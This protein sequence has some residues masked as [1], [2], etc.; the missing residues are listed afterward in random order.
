MTNARPLSVN[1]PSI[2]GKV[3]RDSTGNITYAQAIGFTVYI[4]YPDTDN[5]YK[6]ILSWEG[7]FIKYMDTIKKE[8]NKNGL[9]VFYFTYKS[10]DDSI[11][12]STSGDIVFIT[13][14][15]TIMCTFTC[16]ALSRFRNRVTGHGLAGMVGLLAVAMG[17]ASAFGIVIICK[18]KFVS[19]VGVLPFLV[20]GV[21]I[22]DMFIIL[23]ELDRTN[24][25]LET[26]ELLATVLSN[27]GG[28]VTMTTLTDLV[29]FAVSTMSAFPAIQIFCTYAA[30]ALTFS[31]LMIMTFFVAFLVYEVN[32]IK[33]KRFDT[34]P[35][36]KSTTF[37]IEKEYGLI[38]DAKK[39]ISNVVMTR[40]GQFLMMRYVRVTVMILSAGLLAAGVVGA[41]GIT[42][43]FT[44]Q[45]LGKDGSEYIKFLD[46]DAAY[47]PRP[48]LVNIVVPGTYQL[49]SSQNQDEY[50]KLS[51]IAIASSKDMK[52]EKLDWFNAFKTWATI[53]G[54]GMTGNDFMPSLQMFLSIPSNA[55]YATDVKFSADRKSLL[56]TRIIVY[57]TDS[58]DSSKLKDG[59]LK[60]RD[61]MDKQSK[62]KPYLAAMQFIFAEQ[63]V[64]VKPE[65]TR[66]V[67]ICGITV[68]IMTAPFL[69]HP[70]ILILMV[71][72]FTAFIFE[73]L[74]LMAIWNVS[75][76]SI[77]LVVLTMA[78]GF[79]VDYSAH[80]MHAY[81]TSTAE[82]SKER[83]SDA[84]GTTG[85][86][87]LMGGSYQKPIENDS[88]VFVINL[89]TA[90]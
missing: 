90:F 30:V 82:G 17:I 8:N 80:I 37:E 2:L 6:D 11:N 70:G 89:C 15:F 71:F 66:N 78:I 24:F 27:V 5:Q 86:S 81:I 79:A 10:I 20:L 19:T 53:N 23:D 39:Q 38:C 28:S 4:K 63:Y 68:V 44:L 83:L 50:S 41:L 55:K 60:L 73:L 26:R 72:S 43:T 59:M 47:F 51:G 18:V 31:Y 77:S 21:A 62:I 88:L 75:L 7:K 12:E 69:L 85:A 52:K 61:A 67:I 16:F 1:L 46:T 34:V 40:L 48:M 64:L 57:M 29:A 56:A 25:N 84:L 33:Q 42:E 32:R 54:R 58:L 22:D 35:F 13:I 3:R 65:T 9:D 49:S 74:G 87:V 45:M 76:N 36:V 14:T